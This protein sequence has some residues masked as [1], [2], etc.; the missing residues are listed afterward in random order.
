MAD[1]PELHPEDDFDM[2]EIMKSTDPEGSAVGGIA[3]SEFGA[4]ST[5]PSVFAAGQKSQG[6]VDECASSFG[7]SDGEGSSLE[8]DPDIW[9]QVNQNKPN[10][11]FHESGRLKQIKM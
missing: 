11:K 2:E 7:P 4:G 1:S 8:S 6:G 5:T 9:L 3:P 10:H